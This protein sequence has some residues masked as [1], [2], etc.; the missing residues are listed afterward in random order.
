MLL[1]KKILKENLKKEC[2]NSIEELPIWNWWKI[3]ETGSLIY[4]Y[5]DN[6]Y[7][8]E[9]YSLVSLWTKLHN[10]YLDKYGLTSNL[11]EVL[12]LKKEWIKKQADYIITGNRFN[13][14]ELDIIDAELKENMSDSSTMT[15][16]ESIIFLEEKLGRELNPKELTV[17]KYNDYIKYYSK[18]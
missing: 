2:Y 17:V 18:K 7:S 6:N 3:T 5:K 16:E 12:K 13:L 4:L 10:E 11:K 9:D 8:K 15:K 14:T 1:L